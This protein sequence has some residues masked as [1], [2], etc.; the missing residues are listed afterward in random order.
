MLLQ[1][2]LV[3]YQCFTFYVI[4]VILYPMWFYRYPSCLDSIHCCSQ[5]VYDNPPQAF[6]TLHGS[7]S[8]FAK[9][10]QQACGSETGLLNLTVSTASYIIWLPPSTIQCCIK[11]CSLQAVPVCTVLAPTRRLNSWVLH[12][13][14]FLL[15]W[16]LLWC[17]RGTMA[18]GR[19]D[20][21]QIFNAIQD[22][23]RLLDF[24][25]DSLDY[26]KPCWM[27]VELL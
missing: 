19:P 7:V 12:T 27:S 16:T 14:S 21:P 18:I 2:T 4:S 25:Q 9:S 13:W 15:V 8:R 10:N 5:N 26:C 6:N 24:R 3:H 11:W 20:F 17:K 23:W 22:C 1:W